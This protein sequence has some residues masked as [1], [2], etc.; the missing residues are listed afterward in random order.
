MKLERQA[1]EKEDNA[2]D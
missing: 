1:L 2:F